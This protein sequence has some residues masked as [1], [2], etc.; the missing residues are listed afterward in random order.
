MLLAFQLS[1]G[2][3]NRVRVHFGSL[4]STQEAR[5][6]AVRSSYV[7]FSRALHE[8]HDLLEHAKA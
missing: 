4:E 2:L 6:A 8:H 1:A 3:L 7:H 5:V